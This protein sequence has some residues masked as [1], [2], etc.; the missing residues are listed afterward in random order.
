MC[1]HGNPIQMAT[2]QNTPLNPEIQKNEKRKKGKT[3]AIQ[4]LFY[5]SIGKK[6]LLRN[7]TDVYMLCKKNN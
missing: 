1:F 7:E 3:D 6:T 5:Y 4:S 2:S